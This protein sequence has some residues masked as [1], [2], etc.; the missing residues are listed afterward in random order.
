MGRSRRSKSGEGGGSGPMLRGAMLAEGAR[1]LH[2]LIDPAIAQGVERRRPA[3]AL[4]PADR[5]RVP[6]PRIALLQ[7]PQHVLEMRQR[8]LSA[9]LPR[10]VEEAVPPRVEAD[11]RTELTATVDGLAGEPEMARDVGDAPRA[12]LDVEQTLPFFEATQT[13]RAERIV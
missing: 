4:I 2:D 11:E 1:R 5:A 8:S 3:E 7:R 9:E 13:G 12:A 6:H 10:G